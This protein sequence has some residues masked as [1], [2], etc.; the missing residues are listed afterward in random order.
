MYAPFLLAARCFGFA[1]LAAA[2]R[3]VVAADFVGR[4]GLHL[5][6]LLAA[7]VFVDGNE[8]EVSAGNVQKR[9]GLRVFDPDFDADFE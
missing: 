2:K 5:G 3:I 6:K 8:D 9:P 7:A 1:M 4:F